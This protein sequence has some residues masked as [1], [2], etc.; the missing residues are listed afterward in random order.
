[1]LYEMLNVRNTSDLKAF[2]D[3]IAEKC[4]RLLLLRR[5]CFKVKFENKDVYFLVG[6]KNEKEAMEVIEKR[7]Y[8]GNI[9]MYE[10]ENGL[11]YV[12]TTERLDCEW[13][14]ILTIFSKRIE[15][16]TEK[17]VAEANKLKFEKLKT[18]VNSIPDAVV[19]VDR[20]GRIVEFNDNFVKTMS[21][22]FNIVGVKLHECLKDKNIEKIIELWNKG[23]F[24]KIKIFINNRYF[25]GNVAKV[26]N[27]NKYIVIFR[28]ITDEEL[29][30]KR[31]QVLVDCLRS[32]IF[33][34]DKNLKYILVNDAFSKFVGLP[35][36]DIIGKRDED[37]LPKELAEVCRKSDI[38]VL[39][40]K[41]ERSFEV[42][43]DRNGKV[44]YFEGYKVPVISGESVSGIVGV[45]RDVTEKK[46]VENLKRFRTLLDYSDDAIFIVDEK[47]N[48]IDMNDKAREW[49]NGKKNVT[50]VIIGSWSEKFEGIVG[51]KI[52][53]VSVKS[54]KFGN[55][56]YKVVIAKD[57]TELKKA[58]EKIREMNEQLRFLNRLLRH[59]ISNNLTAILG[60]LEIYRDTGESVYLDKID[61]IIDT[62][63]ELINNVREAESVLDAELIPVKL[64]E[65]IER[66]IENV[67]SENVSVSLLINCKDLT[68]IADKL[69]YSVFENILKNAIQHNLEK[70]KIISVEV[71]CDREFVEVKIA[72][73][74]IG[75]PDEIK[76][77]VFD[78]GFK[79][80]ETGRTGMGLYI[81]KLLMDKY[82]GSI[83]VKDNIPKGT[84]FVL[85][86]KRWK[87]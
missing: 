13:R 81:V 7:R 18:L 68:V 21:L 1:M 76:K 59:D 55:K 69:I 2:G 52:V 45:I 19:V 30:K 86:F 20:E 8:K 50:D 66:C 79:F 10:F 39:K 58:E 44:M 53:L 27:E 82:G 33:M 28:D 46:I 54:A 37:I 34:K 16:V 74:G 32:Y 47:G 65:V 5:M 31:L 25:E 84:V 61:S 67:I 83:E 14:R 35:K 4:S 23:I 71:N 41:K 72:D 73:N 29:S 17:I 63:V 49:S 56:T 62:C 38:E 40:M 78:R 22:N 12:E 75:I 64:D 6:F 36:E 51:D 77:Y 43:I 87:D 9:F 26:R 85:K 57:V 15:E 70:K 60:F 42:Q 3:E 11:F 48:I 24:K 80:G